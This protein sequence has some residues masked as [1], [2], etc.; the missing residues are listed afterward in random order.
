MYVPPAHSELYRTIVDSDP[1][2]WDFM[3]LP[4]TWVLWEESLSIE[5]IG[6]D[7]HGAMDEIA[8]PDFASLPD[9]DH[10]KESLIRIFYKGTPF[11]QLP[12]QRLDGGRIVMVKPDR[13]HDDGTRYLTEFEAQL[14]QIMS[15][16]DFL[17]KQGGTIEVEIRS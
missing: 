17:R 1:D 6:R 4:Q 5:D 9:P 13:D 16:D 12:I 7:G 14:S 3:D 2:A 8:Q 15:P 11:K 10:D